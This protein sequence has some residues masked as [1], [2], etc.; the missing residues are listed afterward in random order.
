MVTESWIIKSLELIGAAINI[1][2]PL[3]ETMENSKT[4]LICSTTDLGTVEKETLE[5]SKGT[6]CHH[7]CL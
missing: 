4:N 1:V 6:R 3:K 2:N 5:S 7:Y